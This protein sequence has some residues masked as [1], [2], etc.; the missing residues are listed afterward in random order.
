M[1]SKN[2]IKYLTNLQRK[3]FRLTSKEFVVEGEKMVLEAVQQQKERVVKVFGIPVFLEENNLENIDFEEITEKELKQISTLTTPNKALVVMR[4]HTAKI[5]EAN[6]YLAL[7]N[8]QDP[9]NLGSIIRLADWYGIQDIICSDDCVD[10]YNPKVVQATM[11]SIFRVNL[12]Y[13]DL[14]SFLK[15]SKLPI[16]GAL[17]NGQNVYQEQLT[18]S[19]ILLMGNEGNGIREELLPLITNPLTIPRFGEAESLNVG[20]ATAILVSEFFR[21][22]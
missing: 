8:I 22:S 18:Q 3:K 17:L 6:F 9:G 21:K 4:Q 10:C 14:H 2:T 13:V 12:H 19:G 7:D 20:F 1:L 15:N 11:G 5:G 16:Y